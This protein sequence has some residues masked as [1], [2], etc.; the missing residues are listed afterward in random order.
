MKEKS[1]YLFDF[2]GTLT[3]KDSMFD[4]LKFVAP[5]KFY[6]GFIFFL[7]LFVLL[8]IGILDAS[9]IKEKFIAFFLKGKPKEKLQTWAENYF[10]LKHTELLRENA[11]KYIQSISNPDDRYMVSA[12]MDI[13]LVPF[14]EY[15]D[16]QLICTRAHWLQ[17]KYSGK[18]F[19]KN[20]NGEEKA[21]RIQKEIPLKDYEN[22]IAFGDTSGDK[23]MYELSTEFH[24]QFFEKS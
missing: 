8:K 10:K 24:H 18:F 3:V 7:P 9:T 12:S 1:V 23:P 22:I 6:I 4:F 11:V 2:D 13:W 15:L 16:L 20:C 17:G 19:G 21:N 5:Y 14:A